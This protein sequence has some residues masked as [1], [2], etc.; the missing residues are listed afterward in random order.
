MV[1][2]VPAG[3]ASAG[4]GDLC[5]GEVRRFFFRSF[6][7]GQEFEDFSQVVFHRN[8][9]PMAVLH[10]G[11]DHGGVMPGIFG[12]KK[13]PILHAQFCGPHCVFDQVIIDLYCAFVEVG[14]EAVPLTKGIAESLAHGVTG[15]V[16]FDQQVEY[17]GESL[18]DGATLAGTHGL[19]KPG[20]GFDFSELC[21]D[22]IEPS[23]EVEDEPALAQRFALVFLIF[24]G[25]VVF[26]KFPTD[27]RETT[28][29][30]D[31][32]MVAF[33]GFVSRPAVA[34]EDTG[35]VFADGLDESFLAPAD[36]PMIEEA[37]MGIVGEP[38]VAARAFASTFHLTD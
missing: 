22:L 35:V 38:E 15:S 10:D 36:P 17:F 31:L 30:E 29:E 25:F 37:A 20:A 2:F 5:G 19:P 14:L 26:V 8:F 34:L 18:N 24:G 32:G 21:F 28:H 9:K 23:H 13:E 11:V 4:G 16:F 33:V 12:S 1:D 6:E 3:I 27:M 7:G